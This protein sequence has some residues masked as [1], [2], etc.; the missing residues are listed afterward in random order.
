MRIAGD[1]LSLQTICTKSGRI[2]F[3]YMN[4]ADMK[5]TERIAGLCSP[6][7]TEAI[8]L[9]DERSY[10]RIPF[11]VYLGDPL[12]ADRMAVTSISYFSVSRHHRLTSNTPRLDNEQSE[13]F[14]YRCQPH[15]N[16]GARKGEPE[17]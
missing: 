15:R 6:R 5:R 14:T 9:A 4:R 11:V 17:C 8:L 2:V 16:C 12:A 13:P 1:L 7:R 3:S 10:E